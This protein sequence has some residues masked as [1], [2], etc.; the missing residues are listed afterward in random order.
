MPSE[1]ELPPSL[2]R[3]AGLQPLELSDLR[4]AHDVERLM[5]ALTHLSAECK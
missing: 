3:L 1:D 2:A 4:W 5:A